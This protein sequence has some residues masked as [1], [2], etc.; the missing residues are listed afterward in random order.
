V[1][2]FADTTLRFRLYGG[3]NDG[4][5]VAAS[6]GITEHDAPKGSTIEFSVG[7]DDPEA[8]ALLDRG[9]RVAPRA[10]NITNEF[11]R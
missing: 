11:V 10:L 6:V 2:Y 5:E 4:F 7:T 3:M 9:E 1:E 8:E